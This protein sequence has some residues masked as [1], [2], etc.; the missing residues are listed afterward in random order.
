MTDST[1]NSKR[2][3]LLKFAATGIVAIPVSGLLLNRTAMAEDLPHLS[4]DDP[5]A[6]ALHYVNDAT[7]STNPKYVKGHMCKNCNLVKGDQG[8]WRGCSIFPGK[9]VH[10]NGWCMAWVG[11]A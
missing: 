3:S 5:T 1:I 11:R 7:T 10:Q 2:R 9:A 4:E 6:K 8:E